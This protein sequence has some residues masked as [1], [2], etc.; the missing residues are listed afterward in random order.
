[1]HPEPEH[2]D[3]AQ[4][5]FGGDRFWHGLHHLADRAGHAGHS[6]ALNGAVEP[7]NRYQYDCITCRHPIVVITVQRETPQP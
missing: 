4:A 2:R 6:R 3:V 1:M 5:L 7:D